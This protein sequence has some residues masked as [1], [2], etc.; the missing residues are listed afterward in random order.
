M[1]V[2]WSNLLVN[3]Y[4]YLPVVRCALSIASSFVMLH[5]E[6]PHTIAQHYNLY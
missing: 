2:I 4:P 1:S 6:Y 3:P 5:N